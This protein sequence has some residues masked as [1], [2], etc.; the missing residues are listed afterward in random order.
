MR[1]ND[2]VDNR[3]DVDDK[4]EEPGPGEFLASTVVA[5]FS[6]RRFLYSFKLT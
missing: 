5:G 6:L 4:D 2:V 3:D 1:C